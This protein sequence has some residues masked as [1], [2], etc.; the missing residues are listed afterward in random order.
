MPK[1]AAQKRKGEVI[2]NRRTFLVYCIQA[3]TVNKK[4]ML[5]FL[6]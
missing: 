3:E 5:D 6:K 2:Q 1:Y 4:K